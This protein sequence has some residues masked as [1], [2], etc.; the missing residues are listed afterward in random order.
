MKVQRSIE[1]SASP[2][3]LWPLLTKRENLLRWHANAQA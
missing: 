2:E 3:K 1:I